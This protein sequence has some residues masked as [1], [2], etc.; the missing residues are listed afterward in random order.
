MACTAVPNDDLLEK[1]EETVRAQRLTPVY[2]PREEFQVGD[3]FLRS[4]KREN[5]TI[6]DTYSI[7]LGT[8]ASMRSEA[9]RYLATRINHLDTD[10]QETGSDDKKVKFDVKPDQTDFASGSVALNNGTRV[11]LPLAP[12]PVI[13]GVATSAGSFGG[14]GFTQ[15]FGLSFGASEQ[16]SL[17]FTDSRSFGVPLGAA[18]SAGRFGGEYVHRIC[19]PTQGQSQSAAKTGAEVMRALADSNGIEEMCSGERICDIAVI[20][21]TYLTRRL[22]FTYSGAKVAQ[23]AAAQLRDPTQIPTTTLAVPGNVNLDITISETDPDGK[24]LKALTDALTTANQ[25]LDTSNKSNALNFLGFQGNTLSF[26]RT[27]IK[28]VAFAYE[29]YDWILKDQEQPQTCGLSIAD[30]NIVG[31]KNR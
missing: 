21:R 15:S 1:Y 16:V 17:D 12:F 20:T 2:P 25:S 9:N 24:Q 31:A 5:P 11:T 29:S 4:Y 27:Y 14:Y 7:W 10:T 8:L 26:D 28:P 19:S 6:D 22:V 30:V 23:L 13:T 18:A 3:V